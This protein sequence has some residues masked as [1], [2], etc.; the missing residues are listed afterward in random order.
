MIKATI[1]QL[2]NSLSAYLRKVR[3]GETVL[4]LD[5]QEP[6]AVLERIKSEGRPEERLARLERA[7]VIRRS[8]TARTL[9]ALASSTAPKVGASVVEALI[10][11]RHQGR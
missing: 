8:H 2:K 3:S 1:S 11:E 4:I 9:E 6:I 5:R 10:E 7:G